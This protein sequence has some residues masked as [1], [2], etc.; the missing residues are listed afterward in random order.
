M[1]KLLLVFLGFGIMGLAGES[2]ATGVPIHSGSEATTQAVDAGRS[3]VLDDMVKLQDKMV[4]SMQNALGGRET[5]GLNSLRTNLQG[6]LTTPSET[7][8]S[9]TRGLGNLIGKASGAVTGTI[10]DTRTGV[11]N[12]A[13]EYKEIVVK[14]S[15]EHIGPMKEKIK[16]TMEEPAVWSEKARLTTSEYAQRGLERARALEDSASAALAKAWIVQAE[17]ANTAASVGTTKDE[18]PNAESQ[19]A[20]IGT[21]LRLQD[22]T[23][24]NLNTR[25]SIMAEELKMDSLIAL[26]GDTRQGGA[27]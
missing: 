6:A 13:S 23:Q 12:K 2:G 11:A 7:V 20:I 5:F 15:G 22:E 24:K 18:L 17:S 10:Q 27:P 9:A 3:G 19:Q 1:N 21:I 4:D 14:A 8:G 16:G 26:D 25:L